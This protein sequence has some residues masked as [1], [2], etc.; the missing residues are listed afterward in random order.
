MTTGDGGGHG[1]ARAES[2]NGI[3]RPDGVRVLVVEREPRVLALVADALGHYGARVTAVSSAVAA[4]DM[5][6]RDK[7]DALVTI[8][9]ALRHFGMM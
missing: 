6:K 5:L 8:E 4:L 2:A 3:S 1:D 9:E 7:P